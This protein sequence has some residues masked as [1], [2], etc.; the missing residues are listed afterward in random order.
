[1]SLSDDTIVEGLST[2]LTGRL[3][4][5]PVSITDITRSTEGWS[6]QTISF[7]AERDQLV[8]TSG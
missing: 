5:P 3:T 7:I 2:F 4:D 8:T 6:R 1:M